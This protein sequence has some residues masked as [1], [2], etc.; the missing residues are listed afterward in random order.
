MRWTEAL[1]DGSRLQPEEEAKKEPSPFAKLYGCGL[2]G[3][4]LRVGPSFHGVDAWRGMSVRIGMPPSCSS[5][6]DQRAD[7]VAYELK[8]WTGQRVACPSWH[9]RKDMALVRMPL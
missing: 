6:G 8:L 2:L 4:I 7:R 5:F 1:R 3:G 9:R